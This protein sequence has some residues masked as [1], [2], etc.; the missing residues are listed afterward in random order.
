MA[1]QSLKKKSEYDVRSKEDGREGKRARRT[2]DRDMQGF[3]DVD[4]LSV[5]FLW[6]IPQHS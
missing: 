6:L 5:R 2:D 4:G 1:M 3:T